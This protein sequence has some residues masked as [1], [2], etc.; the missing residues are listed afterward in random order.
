MTN[1]EDE[2]TKAKNHA[3][4]YDAGAV[5]GGIA[6]G[7]VAAVAGL[8]VHSLP[9]DP[10]HP[11]LEKE[12]QV[13]PDNLAYEIANPKLQARWKAMRELVQNIHQKV[14]LGLSE[15]L[16]SPKIRLSTGRTVWTIPR[17]KARLK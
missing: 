12:G 9:G 4:S 11:I 6:V 13:S 8:I 2:K 16:T 5:T 17:R 15:P 1:E 7:L 10:L 14:E 3:T